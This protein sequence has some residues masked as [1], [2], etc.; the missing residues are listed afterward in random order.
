LPLPFDPGPQ[1]L[2]LA[3]QANPPPYDRARAV[4]VYSGAMRGLI[5][6]LKYGD[7]EDVTALLGRLLVSPMTAPLIAEADVIVPVPLAWRRLVWRRFN[8]AAHLARAAGA[9]C[10]KP[11]ALDTLIRQRA[12][13]AQ[14]GLTRVQRRDN[15]RGAFRVAKSK[16]AGIEGKRVLLIDDV[17]TTGST[18]DAAS[19]ALLRGGAKAVDVIALAMVPDARRLD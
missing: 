15:V 14:V 5:H 16:R 9:R 6:L 17:I 13:L 19:R 4:A 7:R 8:Q 2:S 3:A 18:I 11:V 1:G 12:T 10:E